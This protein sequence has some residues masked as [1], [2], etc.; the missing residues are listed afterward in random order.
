M[1]EPDEASL[2]IEVITDA[3]LTAHGL[4]RGGT[5][6]RSFPCANPEAVLVRLDAMIELPERKLNAY[7]INRILQGF[8]ERAAF[9]PVVAFRHRSGAVRLLQGLHRVRASLAYGFIEIPATL[10]SPGEAEEHGI[11]I[12]G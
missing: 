7:R 2:T 5:S 8:R 11:D 12:S 4:K 9:P 3:M 10:I 1:I 6:A